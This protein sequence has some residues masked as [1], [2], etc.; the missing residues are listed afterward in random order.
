[1]GVLKALLKGDSPS[2]KGRDLDP[3]IFAGTSVGS[4][5]AAILASQPGLPALETVDLLERI[6]LE[7][8]AERARLGNGV[9]RFRGFPAGLT[10]ALTSPRLGVGLASEMVRDFTFLA[11]DAIRRI[12]NLPRSTEPYSRRLVELV[13]LSSGICLD[14]F[15]DLLRDAVPVESILAS[16]RALRIATTRWKTGEL[17]VFRNSKGAGDG[18]EAVLSPNNL[19]DAIAASSAVPGIF[20]PVIVEGSPHV[21]GGVV[22][23]TPLRPAIVAGATTLHL[24]YLDPDVRDIPLDKLDNTLD[25]ME[26]LS[27]QLMAAITNRDIAAASRV[28]QMLDMGPIKD[29]SGARSMKKLTI[30]RY[31]PRR[32]LGGILGMLNFGRDRIEELIALGERDA[33]GHDCRECA[34][35]IP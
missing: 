34:C 2:T 30:H 14:P 17:R 8:V 9:Y 26:R 28:N 12:G 16:D 27:V 18:S 32:D 21:D 20:P 10:S 3:G 5:N 1:L 6:W 35:V 22:M 31:R 11:D 33:R 13:N 23:N 19:R 25:S 7:K 15:R 4:F 24:I 29:T